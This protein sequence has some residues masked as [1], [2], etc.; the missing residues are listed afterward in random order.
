MRHLKIIRTVLGLSAVSAVL[1]FGC[2]R[3]YNNGT[4]ESGTNGATI[5]AEEYPVEETAATEVTPSSD[6]ELSLTKLI[7]LIHILG[8]LPAVHQCRRYPH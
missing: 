6:K 5:S 7:Y 1:I 2:S 8:R 4:E 3:L